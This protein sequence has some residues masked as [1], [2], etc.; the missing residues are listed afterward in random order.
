MA[1]WFWGRFL[2]I[3]RVF[4]LFAIISP[5]RKVIPFVLTNLNL[6]HLRMLCAKSIKIGPVILE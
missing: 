6:L 4:Q 2:K 3:F 1:C 5:W